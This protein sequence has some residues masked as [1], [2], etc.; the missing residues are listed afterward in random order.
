MATA[1]TSTTTPGPVS[2]STIWIEKYRP[3]TLE[4]VVGNEE[5]IKRLRIISREGNMPNLMLAGPPGTGK[6]TCVLCLARAMLGDK[7]KKCVMEL[8]ASDDRGIDVVRDKIK[9]FAKEL[10]SLP[11]GKH[12]IVILDEV[13]S[14]TEAAQQSLR[15]IIEQY[16]DTTRFALACNESTKVI[17]PIQSRC[18]IIRFAKLT[19]EQ[20]INYL[21]AAVSGFQIVNKEN[22]LRVCDIPPPEKIRTMIAYCLKGSWREAHIVAQDLCDSGYNSMDIVGTTRS[23]L[24]RY[25]A[26]EHIVLEYI[27]AIGQ[28]HMVVSSGLNSMLQIDKMISNL[29]KI[30][31]QLR[32]N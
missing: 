12:K 4:D 23:V 1:A 26:P 31:I 21:Q 17:E 7:Y 6:T 28:T 16:S 2:E 5:V 29:C 19:D 14:M 10:A 30:S 11:M 20:A 32:K 3:I 22:V 9:S 8:N 27:K 15:R 13:D 24:R 18:A 25:E